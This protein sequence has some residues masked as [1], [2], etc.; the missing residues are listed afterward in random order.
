MTK[1]DAIYATHTNVAVIRGDDAFDASGNPVTYDESAV[2]AY[3]DAHAYKEKR[4]KEYP[5]MAEQLDMIFHNG[6]NAWKEQ[7]QAVKDKYPKG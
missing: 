1:H 4:Q 3:I 2:Q 6:I 7:I 5:P